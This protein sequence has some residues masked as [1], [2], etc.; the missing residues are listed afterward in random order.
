M[1]LSPIKHQLL[2][3][4]RQAPCADGQRCDVYRR[5]MFRLSHM[6]MRRCMI[7]EEHTN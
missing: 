2:R 3:S 7:V 6:E 1:Q 4:A 5:L